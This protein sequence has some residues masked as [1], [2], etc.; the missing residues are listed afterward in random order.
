MSS[1][2]REVL[3]HPSAAA[4][5]VSALVVSLLS[6]GCLVSGLV[7]VAFQVSDAVLECFVFIMLGSALLV[8]VSLLC[9]GF[10]VLRESKL[11]YTTMSGRLRHLQQL[12]RRTGDVVRRRGEPYGLRERGDSQ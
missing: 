10:S 7:A 4:M 2:S 3:V 6:L 11:G 8:A 9:W 12:D 5:W 1:R